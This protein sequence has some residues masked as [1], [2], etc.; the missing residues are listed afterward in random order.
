MQ[1]RFSFSL[2]RFFFSL[3]SHSL[4]YL[5]GRVALLSV[6]YRWPLHPFPDCGFAERLT[7]DCWRAARHSVDWRWSARLSGRAASRS[8]DYE[9]ASY[10]CC[11]ESPG[12]YEVLA[13]VPTNCILPGSD[14]CMIAWHARAD[15][16][17]FSLD[18]SQGPLQQPLTMNIG[19]KLLHKMSASR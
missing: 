10:C 3:G 7:V 16:Y 12:K 6:D 1:K 18:L 2:G 15:L 4:S 9:W 11:N 19:V 17:C 13:C 5:R 8:V 14:A